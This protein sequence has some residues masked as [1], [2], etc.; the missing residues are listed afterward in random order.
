LFYVDCE[1]KFVVNKHLDRHG[2]FL[3]NEP[4]LAAEY[5]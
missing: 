3:Y 1:H 4:K 2:C 5:S